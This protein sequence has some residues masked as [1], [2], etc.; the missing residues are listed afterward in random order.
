MMNS[1]LSFMLFVACVVSIWLTV[2]FVLLCS[3]VK[4]I[5]AMLLVAYNLEEHT[6]AFSSPFYTKRRV[7]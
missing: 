2:L 6:G 4:A 3:R 7:D 5:K 1:D